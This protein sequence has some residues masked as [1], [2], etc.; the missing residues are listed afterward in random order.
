MSKISNLLE[1]II[2]LQYKGLTTASELSEILEVDK[3]TIY[4]YIRNLNEASV[5][6]YTKKGRN[7]GFY[8]DQNFYIKPSNLSE[9]EL[10]AL[11]MAEEILTSKNGFVYEKDLKNAI[12]KVKSVNVNKNE[13]LSKINDNKNFSINYVGNMENLEDKISKINYSMSRGR[14]LSINYFSVNK[15]NL[16]MR[17]I[18]PYDL[19]FKEG[20]WYI[21]GYCH[22]KG[23]IRS[24]KLNRVKNL[25]ISKDIYM[26]PHTFSLKEY[27]DKNW[28]IFM[29]DKIKVVIKFSEKEAAFIKDTTW[30]IHQHIDQLEGGKI[31]FTIYLN[32]LEDIKKWVLSFGKDAE[33]IEPIE[34]RKDIK[35]ELEELYKIY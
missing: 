6:I 17:K 12:F 31:L 29:G 10:E 3:K 24:F 22:M 13:D 34:L 23:D 19:I 21:I 4:R 9:N 8:I 1:I 33:I 18:D 28:G 25:K 7:G 16:T 15:N 20:D 35:R 14:S 5:P 30:H 27:L 2:M 11:L 26:R 32:E